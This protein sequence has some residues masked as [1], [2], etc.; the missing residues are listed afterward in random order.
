METE[1]TNSQGQEPAKAGKRKVKK[2]L[3][4]AFIDHQFK[5][6]Q[7]G[8]PEGMRPGTVSITAA[9]RR[10]LEEQY[11]LKEG[12]DPVVRKT[13]LDKVVEAILEN[14]IE[15][16]QERSLKDIWSYMDGLPKGELAIDVDK[17]NLAQ[18]TEFFRLA[19]KSKKHG[20][21]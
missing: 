2:P 10:K 5:P 7:S 17:E 6:G 18:L 1:V 9:I 11:P 8:N 12:E 14:G 4:K 19:S 15:K 21:K 3:S 16:K 13:Y 20:S